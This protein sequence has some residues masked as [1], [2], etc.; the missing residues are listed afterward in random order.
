MICAKDFFTLKL[1]FPLGF[2]EQLVLFISVFY[3]SPLENWKKCDGWNYKK[4]E[5]K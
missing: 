3:P 2:C 5:T 1:G 4:I